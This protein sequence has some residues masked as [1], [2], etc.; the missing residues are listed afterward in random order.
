MQFNDSGMAGNVILIIMSY[1]SERNE[2]ESILSKYWMCVFSKTASAAISIIK[3]GLMPNLLIVDAEPRR[4]EAV[5]DVGRLKKYVGGI[6]IMMIDATVPKDY[7]VQYLIA[8]VVD[9]IY[10]P[11]NEQFVQEHVGQCLRNY[12]ENRYVETG[13]MSVVDRMRGEKQRMMKLT[14][15]LLS[16]LASTIDAKDEYTRGHSNRVSMYSVAIARASECLSDKEMESLVHAALLHDV[17]KIGISDAILRKPGRLSDE[18]YRVIQ[19]HPVIGWNILKN[20]SLL[21]GIS[22]V[23]RWH[24]ERFDGSGYPDGISGDTIPPMAR[25]VSIADSY[26]AMTSDRSYRKAMQIE[27]AVKELKL[28]RGTQFDP[29]LIDTAIPLILNGEIRNPSLMD[30]DELSKVN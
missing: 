17:G 15:Q 27:D 25:I 11:F 23:A 13:L 12:R 16:S 22:W 26:D 4:D 20:V 29:Y 28:G 2:L 9:F 7:E 8:G 6:P 1:E 18:E 14:L 3:N 21:P 19:N 10:K 5:R 30:F 24:H